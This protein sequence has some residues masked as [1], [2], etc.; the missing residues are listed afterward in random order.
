MKAV[1]YH[2]VRPAA[3]DLPHFPYLRLT[4]FERQLDHFA[5][6]YGFVGRDDFV[7]WRDGA[8]APQGVLLT[9]DDGLSDHLEFV[10]PVLQ[11]RGL[12]GLFY[13]PSG[14][15]STG[16]ILDVHKVHLALGKLSGGVALAWLQAHAQE[17]LEPAETR[18]HPSAY[19]AQNS[20]AATKL[21]KRLFN[22]ILSPEERRA[23]LDGLLDHA[24]AG[25]PPAWHTFYLGEG[26]MCALANAGMAVGPH[27]H[28]HEVASALSPQRQKF[29]V[30]ASC[31]FVERVGGNRNWGFCYAYGSPEAFTETT[32]QAVADAGCPFAFAVSAQDITRPVAEL[33]RFELP[34]H[35]C[36]AFPHGTTTTDDPSRRSLEQSRA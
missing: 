32:K 7:R 2:Y 26:G 17:I 9:F 18:S 22:W 4:D 30:D 6:A 36:N 21:V 1:M 11:K 5:E 3:A 24:F 10:L 16:Q 14:P 35:N 8:P 27:G 15:A 20:D 13:V 34:R 31:A 29:E 12:F 19:A 23:T 33:D 25:R 28:N